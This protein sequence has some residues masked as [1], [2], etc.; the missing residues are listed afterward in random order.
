MKILRKSSWF[1]KIKFPD[2]AQIYK[3]RLSEEA[4]V[5]LDSPFC[6]SPKNTAVSLWLD[7]SGSYFF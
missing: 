5:F 2:W 7:I 4:F 1:A 6:E 3:Q